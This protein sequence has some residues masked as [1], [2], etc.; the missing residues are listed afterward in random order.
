MKRFI[1][2]SEFVAVTAAAVAVAGTPARAQ[3][4]PIRVQG[5]INDDSTAFYYAQ[6]SGLFKKAGLDVTIEPG[7][8]G[9]AVAA[10]V[11]GGSYDLGKSSI[12]SIL[13]A[14]EKGI[15]FTLLAPA[16]IQEIAAPYGGMLVLKETSIKSGRD[17]ENQTVALS[18]LS[19]IGR[20][21]VCSWVEKNGGNW[22]AVQFVELPMTQAAG[23]VAQKRVF[24]AETVQPF[25]AQAL[26]TGTYQAL[27]VYDTLGQRFAL[28]VWFTTRD[29][30]AKHP[31]QARAFTRTLAQ[32][33]AYTN[34]HEA[35]TA[36]L[37]AQATNVDVAVFRQMRRVVNGTILA[38]AQ[39]QP[40][41]SAC[42]K[43]G[44]LKASFPAADVI[45]RNAV[46]R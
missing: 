34:A 10:T 29:W 14:H 37:M 40:I 45:D 24:A 12:T 4:V 36:P 7:T 17:V 9:A 1:S 22:R 25:F 39:L 5:N 41:I 18:S 19:S 26:D 30:S 27:P 16:G 23:A 6:K 31:E 15:P 13:E 43:Y 32:A 46:T 3:T 42:T 35:E 33:A 44:S 2:R 38:P 21:A 20:A 28:T 8:S 11:L